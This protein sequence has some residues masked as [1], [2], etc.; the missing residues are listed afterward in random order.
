MYCLFNIK[1]K[2][3]GSMALIYVDFVNTNETEQKV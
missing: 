1:S 3:S 2:V